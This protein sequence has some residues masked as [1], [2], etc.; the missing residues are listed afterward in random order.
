M[1]FI[2]VFALAGALLCTAL[3]ATAQQQE[4]VVSVDL[5]YARE[6]SRT[7]LR[8]IAASGAKFAPQVGTASAGDTLLS[9]NAWAGRDLTEVFAEALRANGAD[10]TKHLMLKAFIQFMPEATGHGVLW[11]LYT[12][13]D[14]FDK[15]QP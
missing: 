14:A 5:F 15:K 12:D 1:R 4:L 9:S 2:N 10:P 7:P 8:L 13:K 3:P 11:F 6:I